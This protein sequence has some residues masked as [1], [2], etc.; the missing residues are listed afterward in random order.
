[1]I[2]LF[3]FKLNHKQYPSSL[4]TAVLTSPEEH[5]NILGSLKWNLIFSSMLLSIGSYL[6]L[7]S[8]PSDSDSVMMITHR[9]LLP[10][11]SYHWVY[12]TEF[13]GSSSPGA[14]QSDL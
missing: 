6:W 14:K 3:F 1:M 11:A 13:N 5:I 8:M 2:L 4:F 7:S 9:Q 10:N 12:L